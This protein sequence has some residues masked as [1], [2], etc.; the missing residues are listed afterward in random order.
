M[1]TEP[2][3]PRGAMNASLSGRDRS[4]SSRRAS[5][6]LALTGLGLALNAC[7]WTA[8]ISVVHPAQLNTAPLGNTFSVAPF[9]GPFP[10]VA[11]RV[12]TLVQDQIAHS[13]NPQHR[14]LQVG[15]GA[16]VD[17]EVLDAH[18][19]ERIEVNERRCSRQVVSGYTSSGSA[20][21]R[22][23]YYPCRDI[24][25]IAE[26]RVQVAFRVT[27]ALGGAVQL[28]RTYTRT[29]TIRT[30]GFSSPFE[31]RDPP[32]ID[33]NVLI[34]DLAVSAV[35]G[36]APAI[37]PWRESLQVEFE[38]C[39]GDANCRAGFEAVQRNDL[40][41]AEALF[42][43][44]VGNAGNPGAVVAPN[45]VDRVAEALYNRGVV[46]SFLGNYPAAALD[47]SLANALRPGRERWAVMRRN[48]DGLAADAVQLQRQ[49]VTP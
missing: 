2:V 1:R 39:A 16:V 5:A 47:L 45:D 9:G 31:S 44:A 6:A 36:F 35:N 26:G 10:A 24:Y 8:R 15:G 25:R 18:A 42:S 13:L 49:G 38:R 19:T 28:A 12:Q 41:G 29:N 23:D 11:A 7:A 32:F 20:L 17:G 33:P 4:G 43:R 34:D 14:L 21:Y 37:L 3:D 46:R 40:A 30:T 27:A 22:T 48:V